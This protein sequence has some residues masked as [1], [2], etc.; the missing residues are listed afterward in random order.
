M[1]HPYADRWRSRQNNPYKVLVP[2][3]MAMWVGTGAITWPWH[4]IS[5]YH[6]TWPCWLAGVIFAGG[7]L[8]YL[9]SVRDFK[10]S[11]LGGVPEVVEGYRQQRLITTGIRGRVRHPIYLGH[12]CEMVAWSIGSG[13]AVNYVLTLFA[14]ITGA[15]MIRMEDKELE[16]R[17]GEEFHAYRRRVPS[18]VPNVRWRTVP[19]ASDSRRPL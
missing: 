14:V 19:L 4:R 3:W 6:S 8:I 10:G 15:V 12:L 11:Q 1:I 9:L 13:L 2:L 16:H 5:L 17:F 18:V 7:V